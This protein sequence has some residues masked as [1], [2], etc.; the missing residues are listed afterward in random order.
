[1]IKL[2]LFKF[3]I[4]PMGQ[5]RFQK[6]HRFQM[7]DLYRSCLNFEVGS[8]LSSPRR[9]NSRASGNLLKPPQNSNRNGI[10]CIIQILVFLFVF[11]VFAGK[12]GCKK[13]LFQNNRN[14]QF[15]ETLYRCAGLYKEGLE[16][17]A[18]NAAVAASV[19]KG[20]TGKEILRRLIRR[21]R[22]SLKHTVSNPLFSAMIAPETG[23]ALRLIEERPKLMYK[24]ALLDNPPF[25]IA[26]FMG[27]L[28]IVTAFLKQDPKLIL[29]E[30]SRGERP[31]HYAW[32][33][34]VITALLNHEAL[35][36]APDKK[37][38]TA[39]HYVRDPKNAEVLLRFRADLNIRDRSG[40][41]LLKYH[42]TIPDNEPVLSLLEEARANLKAQA[43]TEKP[44][45]QQGQ[46]EKLSLLSSEGQEIQ[47]ARK[48]SSSLS[49]T[50]PPFTTGDT[51][52]SQK[53]PETEE[54]RQMK[55]Q[56]AKE[57]REIKTAQAREAR[58]KRLVEELKTLETRETQQTQALTKLDAELEEARAHL[59]YATTGRLIAF[60]SR[61]LGKQKN[62]KYM[63]VRLSKKV[64]DI[65]R[66]IHTQSKVLRVI[67]A[68][69]R[70]IQEALKA[71]EDS[72]LIH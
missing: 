42:E 27:D 16:R 13:D 25:F 7:R 28:E 67:E 49:R 10:V 2:Q 51:A 44:E 70:K 64:T 12:S 30:N 62:L 71:L 66:D 23:D 15:V 18:F 19:E 22:I 41:P 58:K 8:V 54:A 21:G 26:V 50:V 59:Y 31:L 46:T 61:I 33:L 56:R 39:L 48:I 5:K 17:E 9:Q 53:F 37:G 40:L 68:R 3:W 57:R 4:S 63:R 6:N 43:F 52:K 35:P 60:V 45:H 34:K 11:P 69:Q 1:M 24:G 47:E 20:G 55:A 65:R 14:Q 72:S 29:S 32:D 38:M 36:N